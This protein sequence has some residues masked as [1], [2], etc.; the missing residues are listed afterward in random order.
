MRAS[1]AILLLMSLPALASACKV[2]VFR[3]A[4]ER[5]APDRYVVELPP[6]ASRLAREVRAT[7]AN[8]RVV[9]GKG[10]GAAVRL[11]GAEEGEAPLWQGPPEALDLKALCESPARARLVRLLASGTAAVWVVLGPDEATEEMLRAQLARLEKDLELPSKEEAAKDLLTDLPLVARFAIVTVRREGPDEEMLI[12]QLLSVE[13]GLERVKGPIVFPVIGRGRALWAL[14]GAELSPREVAS[15]ARYLCGP[16][17]C[18]AKHE[19]A[20]RDLLLSANWEELLGV[21]PAEEEKDAS[22]H[23]VPIPPGVRPGAPAEGSAPGSGWL[24]PALA[25]GLTLALIIAAAFHWRWRAE[26]R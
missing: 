15:S 2:P 14:H 11:P 20:G 21:G 5:W 26:R 9:D 12:R 25:L 19:N 23:P 3:Y 8:V 10:P 22:P 18:T 13:P 1:A 7:Q 6:G 24:A 17:S 4:L 16:C